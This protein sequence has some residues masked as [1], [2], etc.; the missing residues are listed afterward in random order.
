MTDL[1]EQALIQIIRRQLGDESTDISFLSSLSA[2]EATRLYTL[3]RS[4]DLV[5]FVGNAVG[6]HGD[7][8]D[9]ALKKAVLNDTI[10]LARRFT[11][12]EYELESIRRA[13]DEA[14]IA[15]I[16]LKGAV[17]C[18]LY[19]ISWLRSRGDLD[20]LV[21]EENVEHASQVL[22]DVLGYKKEKISS[23][24]I[25]F[26]SK[27]R[28]NVE[29]HFSLLE[30]N[31]IGQAD[32]PLLQVWE[33]VQPDTGCGFCMT[34]EMTYYYHMAHTAKHILNGGCGI[35]PFIDIWLLNHRITFSRERREALLSQGGLLTFA[36]AAEHLAEVWF[37]HAEHDQITQ[38]LDAYVIR[39]GV[40]GS[41]E[42]HTAVNR[43]KYKT[44]FSAALHHIIPPYSTMVRNYPQLKKR[45]WLMPAYEVWRWI[46]AIMEHRVGNGARK[47]KANRTL[48]DERA[49][50]VTRL[51]HELELE[52]R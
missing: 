11:L 41:L 4:Q 27:S 21:H 38:A 49:D 5:Q 20:I 13:L 8:G 37:G 12:Q 3:A 42:N 36:H 30:E 22:T 24:D 28:V 2:A 25:T 17:L 34:D 7:F 50:G 31:R 23:H 40:Y 9:D 33:Q 6:K 47:L 45:P 14:A 10:M 48:S 35:R 16:P 44:G 32:K 29:L 46:A 26:C 52:M 19:P 51:L 15:Y 1:T 18:A 39:G 43:A